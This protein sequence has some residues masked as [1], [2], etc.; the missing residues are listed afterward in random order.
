[1][2]VWIFV[3]GRS[4]VS[5]LYALYD[6]WKQKLIRKGWGI[7]PIPLD[8]KHKY[9]RKIG[10]RATEKLKND[11]C[12]LVVGLP[13]LYPNRGISDNYRHRNLEELQIV[14]NR[15]VRREL[16]KTSMSGKEIEGHIARFHANAMK[17]D[18]EVLLL[19]ATGQLQSRLKMSNSPSGWRRPPEEQ[20]QDRPPKRIVEELFQRHLKRSYGEIRDS[21]AIL[22]NADMSDIVKQCPTFRAVIDWIGEKTGVPAY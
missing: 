10:P 13:D 17:H 12:D 8:N 15:L 11:P 21:D 3:E 7:Q 5:A 19:A 2:K 20:N 4:D 1:M 22:R 6:G 16:E 9:L 18:M 14:Q